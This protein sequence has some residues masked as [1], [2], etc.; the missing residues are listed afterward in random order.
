MATVGLYLELGTFGMDDCN[1]RE[2]VIL[3]KPYPFCEALL[4]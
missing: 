1:L 3:F 4:S 2:Q